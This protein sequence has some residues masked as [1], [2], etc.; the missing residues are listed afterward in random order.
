ML[1]LKNSLIAAPRFQ[2][3]CA[4]LA[5]QKLPVKTAFNLKTLLNRIETKIKDADRVK[6]DLMK[7]F[8]Q[9]DEEGNLKPYEDVFKDEVTG[10]EKRVPRPGTVVPI[11]ET[12]EEFEKKFEEFLNFEHEVKGSKFPAEALG[13]IELS[14]ADATVLESILDFGEEIEEEGKVLPLGKR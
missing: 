9:K 2:Q 12:K 8:C 5:Q 13:D 7:Q 10:E 1:L 14:A 6:I 3:A 11:P 4:N